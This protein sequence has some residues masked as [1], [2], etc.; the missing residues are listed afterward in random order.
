MTLSPVQN[1]FPRRGFTLVELLVVIGL[2]AVL[3]GAIGFTVLGRSGAGQIPTGERIAAGF[4]FAARSQAILQSTRARVIIHNDE[5]DPENYLRQ[6]GIVY[7]DPDTLGPGGQVTGST[8]WAATSQ[9]ERLPDG[10][11]FQVEDSDLGSGQSVTAQQMNL[12]FPSTAFQ[13]EGTGPRFL[14]YEFLSTGLSANPGAQF[15]L[16]SGRLLPGTTEPT[17]DGDQSRGG[18]LIMRTGNVLI[19]P[20]AGA[21]E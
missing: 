7:A 19:F 18:F 11:F 10:V 2:V 9:G 15:V 14:F 3:A 12:A 20:D 6:I 16:G 5:D 8:Q 17:W 13:P 21:I 1:N 4:F